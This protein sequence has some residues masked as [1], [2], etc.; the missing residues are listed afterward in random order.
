M[1]FYVQ[2]MVL[3]QVAHL[4]VTIGDARILILGVAFKRDVD[5]IRP[6]PALRVMELLTQEGARNISYIDSYVPSPEVVGAR[7][8]AL[9]Y[10]DELVSGADVVVIT[11]DHSDFD[12]ERIV[13]NA[14]VV[15]D[16]RNAT[17]NVKEGR[18]KIYL[19]GG[20]QCIR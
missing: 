8:E 9:P 14:R 4:P 13:A 3:N 15:I 17:K 5:D 7:M 19:L 2:R 6:S 1:P 11:T 16:T 10:S 12:Y 20:G 18:E